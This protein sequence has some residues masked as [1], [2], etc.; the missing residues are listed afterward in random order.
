MV[1]RKHADDGCRV[2]SLKDEGCQADRGSGVTR[3]RLNDHLFRRN[4]GKLALNLVA[5]KFVG[6]DP[7]V[8]LMGNRGKAFHGFLD[9]GLFAVKGQNLLGAPAAAARPETCSTASG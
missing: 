2:N 6:D 7:E 8:L 4:A 5:N 1:C 9:H 3:L